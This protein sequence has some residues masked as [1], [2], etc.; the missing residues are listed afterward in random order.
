VPTPDALVGNG[1]LAADACPSLGRCV[2]VGSY[3]GSSGT[4]A[5]AES[6]N[7][8]AW[9]IQRVPVP[10]SV[11]HSALDGVSCSSATACT[12]VGYYTDN[13]GD[14]VTLAE[15][16]NGVSW[17]AQATP[18]PAGATHSVLKGVSCG[19][20][21][22]C[23]AVGS[24][25][26]SENRATLS[27]WWNG[28]SWTL[29]RARNPAGAVYSVLY[30]VFC[31]AATVCVAVGNDLNYRSDDWLTLAEVWHGQAWKVRATPNP[32]GSIV[33]YLYGVSCSSKTACTAVG[34]FINSAGSQGNTLGAT[35]AE[36]WNGTAWTIQPTPNPTGTNTSSIDALDGVSCRSPTS[37]SAVGY[38]TDGGS[39]AKT[40]A[41]VWNGTAWTIRPAVDPG[42]AYSA[43][44]GVSCDS[45]TACTAVG[46]YR[47]RAGTH[48]AL[49]ESSAG[50]GWTAQAIPVPIGAAPSVL[51][52]VS[53]GSPR[54]CTAVGF[55]RNSPGTTMTLAEAWNGT[56]WTVQRT[57][58]PATAT[59]HVLAGV[60][61]SSESACVAVG[62][63]YG[64]RAG[65]PLAEVWN[66]IT[67]AIQPTAKLP[68]AS[69]DGE[70]SGV[71]CASAMACTAVGYYRDGS[72]QPVP[73]AEAWN[74]TAWAIQP[75]ASPAGGVNIVLNSVSCS[76]PGTC[77]AVGNYTRSGALVALAERWNGAAWTVQPTP[78]GDDDLY[79]VWCR[80]A[81]AC[82]ASGQSY[83]YPA[84]V[85][86]LAEAW[87]HRA[88]S[89]Q[90]TPRIVTFFSSFY[91][92]SCPQPAACAAVGGYDDSSGV[93][94]TLAETWNGTRWAVR[95]TA[96]PGDGSVL[97]G[98]SCASSGRCIAVGSQ[99]DNAGV[100]L[101]LAEAGPG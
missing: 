80:S 30:S 12:A 45:A 51:A 67:W 101:A 82:T 39:G 84:G 88:W 62:R 5:L 83:S 4:S 57:P 87:Q 68:G 14:Q 72:G 75:T 38:Y 56:A 91:G 11:T 34:F 46:Y 100:S 22:S 90:P 65:Y 71:S 93:G 79:G 29:Q 24:S 55:Y 15:R 37:C 17:S 66:G 32:A 97:A 31:T 50:T 25:Y 20:A 53:C 78:A 10:V 35:L 98:V 42:R 36:A 63:S 86:T 21:G 96:R 7:G 94:V 73:L 61:C 19:S 23:V 1:A 95:A 8:T 58:D 74:G 43:L 70:L 60:S 52:G 16:W 59:H 40:L 28:T 6:W 33:S 77:T 69:P 47:E 99:A 81:T 92:V 85:S 3:A 2:A 13:L 48:V 26:G 9:S 64:Q 54:T 49:A 44:Y 76:S 27:E 89:V 41:E 18:N